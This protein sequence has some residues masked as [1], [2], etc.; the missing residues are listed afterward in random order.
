MIEQSTTSV[1]SRGSCA[2]A[3]AS[4]HG[5]RFHAT[6]LPLTHPGLALPLSRAAAKLGY[7][8]R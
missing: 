4:A 5:Y 1:N 2:L 3:I 6:H 7:G 8:L